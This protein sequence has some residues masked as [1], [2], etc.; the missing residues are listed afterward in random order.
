MYVSDAV[1][2]REVR[3]LGGITVSV[4][5]EELAAHLERQ[6]KNAVKEQYDAR[7][8]HATTA[9]LL[10][11]FLGYV[12]AHRFYLGQWRSGLAHFVIFALGAAGVVGGLIASAPTNAALLIAGGVL[13]L[14]SLI[15]EIIDLSRI[16]NE[17]H[18]RNTLL[19]E[20]L[21]AGALLAENAPAEGAAAKPD[22]PARTV[23]AQS[24]AAGAASAGAI[25]AADL[26]EARALA[27]QGGQAAISYHEA[28]NFTDSGTADGQSGAAAPEEPTAVTERNV[29]TEPLPA[30]APAAPVSE[31]DAA[32]HP[33]S[34]PR[35]TDGEEADRAA[36]PSAG[37]ALG[38]GAAALGAAGLG[39]GAYEAAHAHDAAMAGPEPASPEP[40]A[41]W[42]A[43]TQP[44]EEPATQWG[45]PEPE[46]AAQ[47][48]PAQWG[49]P[50]PAGWAEAVAPARDATASAMDATDA[51]APES[52]APVS[53]I[54]FASAAPAFITMPGEPATAPTS[55]AWMEDAYTAPAAGGAEADAV[56]EPDMPLYVTPQEAAP[57][58]QPPAA[59]EPPAESY[60][61][62]LPDV[63]SASAPHP[64]SYR[65]SWEAPT[66]P[67]TP[68]EEPAAHTHEA[69]ALAGLAGL[70]AVAG[71][72]ALAE[73]G[74]A[75]HADEPTPEPEAAVT[76]PMPETA[77]ATESAPVAEPAVAAEPA[78]PRMK[79]IRVKRRIVVEGQVVREEVV[80]REVPADADMAAEARRIQEELASADT[81]GSDEIARLA[82]LSP[83]A[84][85]EVRRNIEG[86][87]PQH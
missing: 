23:A 56:T 9:F 86:L 5:I 12:G 17:I 55:P 74:F 85:I 84:E 64:E 42:D 39:I 40:V 20:G 10:C 87:D 59:P 38:L 6:R 21:I 60:V 37:D 18:Q 36:A 11:F 54:A 70:G 32:S 77:P 46:P 4:D 78:A 50:A 82:H 1:D 16:D 80:E 71:A 63:Y 2:G 14:A 3:H 47:E 53:D 25:T 51:G 62:P 30:S 79:R 28:T 75:Q 65:P 22:Q 19:A 41:Q 67:A 24:S 57:M 15:W 83:D 31:V 49:E 81:A 13:I 58:Y 44:V 66:E 8:T 26:A 52:I 29:V 76:E 7:A 69:E 34:A 72:G 27:D 68:A 33:E 43:P 48:A 35:A 61:P 73:R 45:A